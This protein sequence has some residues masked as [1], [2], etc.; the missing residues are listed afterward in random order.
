MSRVRRSVVAE[1]TNNKSFS[2]ASATQL[3]RRTEEGIV[4]HQAPP[5]SRAWLCAT[6]IQRGVLSALLAVVDGLKDF[7]REPRRGEFKRCCW[8]RVGSHTEPQQH[9]MGYEKI[10]EGIKLRWVNG[11]VMTR[12]VVWIHPKKYWIQCRAS[13]VIPLK[14][15][16][17]S[18]TTLFVLL[19]LLKRWLPLSA[20]F[21]HY[22][23]CHSN[24]QLP[25]FGD[26]ADE[27]QS[28]RNVS[29]W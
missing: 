4:F 12:S 9:P 26:K 18:K 27:V 28:T 22:K 24:T 1:S 29:I 15:L 23:K 13:Y 17:I 10:S 3:E 19:K 2:V 21:I 20:S 6:I 8:M 5:K 7:R 16:T 14:L 11:K 25:I